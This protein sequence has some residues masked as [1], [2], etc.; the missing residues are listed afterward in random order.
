MS[1][2]EYAALLR[3]LTIGMT[4]RYG[5]SCQGEAFASGGRVFNGK[6]EDQ[7]ARDRRRQFAA[8]QRLTLAQLRLAKE[9]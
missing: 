1:R 6:I 8:I 3:N 7:W 9:D 5:L 2:T 4:A